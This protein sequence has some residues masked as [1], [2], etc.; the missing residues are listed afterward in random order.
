MAASM[1]DPPWRRMSIAAWV[2]NGWLVQAIP[3][4]AMTSERV[5]KPRPTGRF[6]ASKGGT[7]ESPQMPKPT[8]RKKKVH[9]RTFT[10]KSGDEPAGR[11]LD[12]SELLR[13]GRDGVPG[14]SEGDGPFDALPGLL[15]EV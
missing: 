9:A 5:T 1:A 10:G 3:R 12:Q 7:R 4:W 2:A 14:Q 6:S 15:Q 11:S 8:P 13:R